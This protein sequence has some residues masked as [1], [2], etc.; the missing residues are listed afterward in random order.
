MKAPAKLI[1]NCRLA[2][3]DVVMLTAAL[4]DL[5]RLY[6]GR[7]VTDVRTPYA[8][9]WR[10]NPWITPLTDGDPEIRLIECHYPLIHRSNREPWHFLHGYS[11]H[12]AEQLDLD[13]YPTAFR[14]DIYLS[15]K[16]KSLP[17]LVE[18][19][20]G[21][22]GPYWIICAGGKYDYTI[23]WWHRRRWQEVV[24][25]L[26]GRIRFVQVGEENDYHPPLR[27]VVD[28]RGR[29][30]LRELI[31][32]VYW[33][34]GVLCPV[35][36]LMHLAAAVPIPPG[37]AGERPAV[38]VAGGREPP[39]WEAYPWHRFLHT[40][41]VLPCCASGGCWRSRTVPLGDGSENDRPEKLCASY[42]A[43]TGLPRCMDLI[44]PSRV[45]ASLLEYYPQNTY[46]LQTQLQEMGAGTRPAPRLSPD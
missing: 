27:G 31:R 26:Q 11:R 43:E 1:L 15:K 34:H 14:G 20:A 17:S 40:I 4:R 38:V 6:P 5:H 44:T 29:T 7:F 37:R 35:T 41:G 30:T 13:I 24:D 19:M 18:R 23:K 32:L 39:H 12:L 10:H 45:V 16:E 46:V 22:A 28:L 33:S 8:D 42:V 36:S 21:E 25:Q 2:V 3:G 9:L